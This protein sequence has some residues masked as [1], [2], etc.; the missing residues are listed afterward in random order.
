MVLSAESN[1]VGVVTIYEDPT[2]SVESVA[3]HHWTL[4]LYTYVRAPPNRGVMNR[5]IARCQRFRLA[6]V[7]AA[8]GDKGREESEHRSSSL[9]LALLYAMLLITNYL[10]ENQID[11]SAT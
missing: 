7:R 1:G 10:A 8:Q 5:P 6:R 9:L 2:S 3:D 11:I 4:V